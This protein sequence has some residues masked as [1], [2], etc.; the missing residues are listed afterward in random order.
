MRGLA[1]PPLPSHKPRALSRVFFAED[2]RGLLKSWAFVATFWRLVRKLHVTRSVS[3][4][5][6]HSCALRTGQYGLRCALL[7]SQ[8]C[9]ARASVRVQNFL[10]SFLRTFLAYSPFGF[11]HYAN[12]PIRSGFCRREFCRSRWSFVI[13]SRRKYFTKYFSYVRVLQNSWS[14][15]IFLRG[16]IIFHA[17]GRRISIDGWS[18]FR[19]AKFDFEVGSDVGCKN[20]WV[21]VKKKEEWRRTRFT[22]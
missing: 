12:F 20:S 15:S 8:I 11:L 13:S 2:K 6:L 3:G 16:K 4:K 17:G 21:G 18:N 14:S 1:G 10:R 19:V 5:A 7:R 22:V 9:T